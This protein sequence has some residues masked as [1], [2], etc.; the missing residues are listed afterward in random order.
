M[1][2]VALPEPQEIAFGAFLAAL[3]ARL[4]LAGQAWSA[5]FLGAVLLAAVMLA[6]IVWCRRSPTVWR[7]HL[8]RWLVL[9]LLLGYFVIGQAV[10]LLGPNR[11]GWLQ[12]ADLALFGGHAS[13][14]LQ[15]VMRPW[16]SEILSAAYMLF[17]PFF[18]YGLLRH[19]WWPGPHA[20]SFLRV[21]GTLWGLGFLGYSLIPAGGPYFEMPGA[22]SAPLVGGWITRLNLGIIG[23]GCNRADCFPSLHAAV[24]AATLLFEFRR[25][26]RAGLLFAP[27]VAALWFSTLYLRQHYVVDLL[28]GAALLGL[29]F[30][31]VPR[32]PDH[33]PGSLGRSK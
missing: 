23:N 11:A 16:L 14:G 7:W 5:P 4:A 25:R 6:L 33:S 21:A 8:R 19:A 20:T 13:V 10:P 32:W 9:T 1:R 30:A 31:V 2:R 15:S 24:S 12:H 22:F 27:A 3:L 29:V 26:L 17:L 18:A 28:A